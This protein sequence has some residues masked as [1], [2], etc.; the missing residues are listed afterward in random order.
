[1][2][3]L[4]LA[5]DE[6]VGVDPVDAEA[7]RRAERHA[8]YEALRGACGGGGRGGPKPDGARQGTDW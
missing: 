5:V 2:P 3:L 1:M 7:E 4:R 6:R 8:H